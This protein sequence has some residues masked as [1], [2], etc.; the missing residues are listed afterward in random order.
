MV[1]PEIGKLGLGKQSEEKACVVD[2]SGC[3]NVHFLKLIN[4]N[5]SP[6]FMYC[7]TVFV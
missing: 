2:K 5:N 7:I 6:A 4:V 3:V 1:E